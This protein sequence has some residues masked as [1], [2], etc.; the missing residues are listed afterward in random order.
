MALPW[1][2]LVAALSVPPTMCAATPTL[3]AHHDAFPRQVL[4][5]AERAA[6]TGAYIRWADAHHLHAGAGDIQATCGHREREFYNVTS[7][8]RGADLFP[9]HKYHSLSPLPTPGS[10]N[11]ST[12]VPNFGRGAV[13]LSAAWAFGWHPLASL[14]TGIGP[15]LAAHAHMVPNGSRAR[16]PCAPHRESRN[17]RSTRLLENRR[18]V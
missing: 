9:L 17:V 11:L 2:T 14:S 6:Y 8:Q 4:A 16:D 10:G 1:H 13:A 12:V 3:R 15:S 7:C 18:T 5:D